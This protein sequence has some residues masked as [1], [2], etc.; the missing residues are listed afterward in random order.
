MVGF[1]FTC[2]LIMDDGGSFP[3]GFVN[4]MEVA[5]GS[6]VGDAERVRGVDWPRHTS[7]STSK[8]LREAQDVD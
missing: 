8:L 7:S 3:M 5:V 6:N 2:R 1:R 4:P